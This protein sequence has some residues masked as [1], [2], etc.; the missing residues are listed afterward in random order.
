MTAL[1]LNADGNF[2]S[3]FPLCLQKCGISLFSLII[4]L[5]SKMIE[6]SLDGRIH[7]GSIFVNSHL[8]SRVL[9]I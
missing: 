1:P 4:K 8:P 3:M 6:E 7:K 9:L 2:N 5:I